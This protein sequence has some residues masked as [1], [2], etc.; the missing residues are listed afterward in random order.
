MKIIN[1]LFW[2]AMAASFALVIEIAISAIVSE[3]YVTQTVFFSISLFSVILI[4]VEEITKFAVM[5]KLIL[6]KDLKASV[7]LKSFFFGLGF[8]FFEIFL[9]LSKFG[10]N[11]VEYSLFSPLFGIFLFHMLTSFYIGYF[12][13]AFRGFRKI[14][15]ALI[16]AF[17]TFLH[18]SYN[19]AI[20]H[21]IPLFIIY[22]LIF[23]LTSV[24]FVRFMLLDLAKYEN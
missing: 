17:M 12:I 14:V 15:F 9:N 10:F 19:L 16:V 1:C 23:M 13:A 2:G 7:F 11:S 21:D 22:S 8:S 24:L 5:F 20:I 6:K 18:L 3:K 4:L